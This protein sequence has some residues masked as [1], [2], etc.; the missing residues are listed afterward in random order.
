MALAFAKPLN[1]A[2]RG[3]LPRGLL[4]RS[5]LII[6]VP[7]LMLQ[8][9]ALQLFYGGHLDVIS[10]RLAGGVAGDVSMVTELLRREP[11]E[12]RS[13]IF[14]EASW[15]LDLA[16]A[17]E[18]GARIHATERHGHRAARG[19][20]DIPRAHRPRLHPARTRPDP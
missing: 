14:R 1:R 13:W 9:V 12:N 18:A 2:L 8:A 5:I 6:L 11:P 17:F 15:R 16:L 7:M 3:V 4:A 10:R 19:G 20:A